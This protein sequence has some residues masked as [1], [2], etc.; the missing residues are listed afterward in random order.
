MPV[1]GAAAARPEREGKHRQ[2]EDG[3]REV[4]RP[5]LF[6]FTHGIGGGG[7]L[8]DGGPV[9]LDK[10]KPHADLQGVDVS[11]TGALDPSI[12]GMVAHQTCAW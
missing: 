2:D 3:G 7:G 11:L 5:C 12:G 8:S 10:I 4:Q 6:G 1:L 9:W